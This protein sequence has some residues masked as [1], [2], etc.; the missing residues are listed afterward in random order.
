MGWQVDKLLQALNLH[1]TTRGRIK[2]DTAKDNSARIGRRNPTRSTHLDDAPGGPIFARI[3]RDPRQ[4]GRFSVVVLQPR[5]G[6]RGHA[7]TH[8]PFRV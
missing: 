2:R 7:A 3:P 1:P 6:R 8:P 4:G 5:T